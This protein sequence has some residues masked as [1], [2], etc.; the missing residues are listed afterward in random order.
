MK[1]LLSSFL[2]VLISVF[3]VYAQAEKPIPLTYQSTM[4]GIGSG[5]FYDTYLS[6]MEYKGTAINVHYEQMKM[7]GLADG[8]IAAQHLFNLNFSWA[9][10]KTETATDYSGFIDYAYGL[11]YKFSP[12]DKWRFFAGG[13]AN[14]LLGFIYNSRNGNNPA[15]GK[16]HVNLNLS[17]I[18]A[19]DF[20][21]KSQ[22]VFLRYQLNVPFVG[23]MLSPE[24]GQS[25]YE[26]GLGNRN[27]LTHFSSFHNYL[28]MR[29]IISAEIPIKRFTIRLSYINWIYETKIND[30]ETRVSNN[31]FLIGLSKN[32]YTVPRKKQTPDK[33]HSVF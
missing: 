13:Q 29:N 9:D 18:A 5:Y 28:A 19:Y 21:I 31:S 24:F 10:N 11:Y 12:L 2:A 26:I 23:I 33:Y 27:G 30:L 3:C 14:G 20:Q 17:A 15:T 22:P 6:P 32:F 4:I 16:G 8:N 7:T 25:Y 1:K